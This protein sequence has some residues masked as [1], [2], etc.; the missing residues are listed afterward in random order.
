VR[1]RKKEVFFYSCLYNYT[2]V[3]CSVCVSLMGQFKLRLN[4]DLNIDLLYD[5]KA[6]FL[7]STFSCGNFLYDTVKHVT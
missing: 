5:E 2:F 1:V 3:Y 6:A 4:L 7:R